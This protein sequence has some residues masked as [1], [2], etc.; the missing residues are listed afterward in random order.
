MRILTLFQLTGVIPVDSL[1]LLQPF[2]NILYTLLSI[3]TIIINFK[4][5]TIYKVD[6]MFILS[7]Y[8]CIVWYVYISC[9]IWF[10]AKKER[11]EALLTYENELSSQHITRLKYIMALFGLI[12]LYCLIS[13]PITSHIYNPGMP[14]Y[15]TACTFLSS[16][17]W[18]YFYAV[19]CGFYSYIVCFAMGQTSSI[20]AWCKGLKKGTQQ[21]T[22]QSIL[23]Q[24][25][26]YYKHSKQFRKLWTN[27]LVLTFCLLTFRIPIS[28]ILLVY[29]EAYY[30]LVLLIF[31][32]Y[33][34]V[35]LVLPICECNEQHGFFLTYFHKHTFILEKDDVEDI[36]QYAS[37]RMLGIQLY[38]FI[39]L[40]KHLFSVIMVLCNIALPIIVGM[41][42]RN[43]K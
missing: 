5:P 10:R 42:L 32:I 35:Q 18:C 20:R 38:G 11:S 8:I 27:V 40:Y 25:T 26:I 14:I 3:S 24:Y 16:I 12:G 17:F 7:T 22:L 19:C 23:E 1:P 6:N 13:I 37:M 9:V 33:A 41:L 30:E 29:N 43:L 4:F 39:P 36:L 21:R 31:Y 2:L 28:F 15:F 34:W